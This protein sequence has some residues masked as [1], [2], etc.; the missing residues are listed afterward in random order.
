MHTFFVNKLF[1]F[2]GIGGAVGASTTSDR[3]LKGR[4]KGFLK[5]SIIGGIAAG[6]QFASGKVTS[7]L[8][9]EHPEVIKEYAEAYQKAKLSNGEAFATASIPN[10][11]FA[12]MVKKYIVDK[13]NSTILGTIA[14]SAIGLAAFHATD[15]LMPNEKKAHLILGSIVHDRLL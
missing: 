7:K 10:A 14:G 2:M 8:L 5:G 4:S 15:K 1:P 6:S 12:D 13:R 11:K 9:K 3:S